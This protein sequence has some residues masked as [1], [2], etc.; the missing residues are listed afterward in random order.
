MKYKCACKFKTHFIV[1]EVSL[2]TILDIHVTYIAILFTK[3]IFLKM[4][5][6]SQETGS[7]FTVCFSDYVS[8][9]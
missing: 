7:H 6:K 9:Y 2:F 1:Y 4:N 5:C 3:I 8:L